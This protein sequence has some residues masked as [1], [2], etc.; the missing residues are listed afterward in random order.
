LVPPPNSLA[1]TL[2]T[3]ELVGWLSI[4]AVF[5]VEGIVNPPPTAVLPPVHAAVAVFG[6]LLSFA[7]TVPGTIW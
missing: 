3:V 5:D 1:V 2:H 4:T 6:E 7:D